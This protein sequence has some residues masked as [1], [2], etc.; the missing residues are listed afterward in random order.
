MPFLNLLYGELD[1]IIQV[2]MIIYINMRPNRIGGRERDLI[3]GS[4][5]IAYTKRPANNRLTM[6]IGIRQGFPVEADKTGAGE[7]GT[8]ETGAGETGLGC[9]KAEAIAAFGPAASLLIFNADIK[10]CIL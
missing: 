4:A 5:N 9:A 10:S 3:P 6:I 1:R 7:T 8:G 2:M